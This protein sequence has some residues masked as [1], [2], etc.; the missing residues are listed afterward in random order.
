MSRKICIQV[1]IKL[2]VI[3]STVFQTNKI[4]NR[5]DD[6]IFHLKNITIQTYSADQ[7]FKLKLEASFYLLFK[8]F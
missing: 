8:E 4:L 3:F 6:K 5:K 2:L 1:L 7:C